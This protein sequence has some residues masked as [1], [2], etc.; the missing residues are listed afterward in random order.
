MVN[1]FDILWNDIWPNSLACKQWSLAFE[2]HHDEIDPIQH[3]SFW[4]KQRLHKKMFKDKGG[5]AD[6]VGGGLF[7]PVD[8]GRFEFE[9]DIGG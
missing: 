2:Q 3:K 8:G 6:V 1:R 9:V 4:P 7:A 5:V